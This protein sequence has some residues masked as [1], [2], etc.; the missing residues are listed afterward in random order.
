MSK[1]NVKFNIKTINLFFSSEENSIF[2]YKYIVTVA[3]CL[4]HSIED[5]CFGRQKL[6]F[7]KGREQKE[8]LKNKKNNNKPNYHKMI[9]ANRDQHVIDDIL[10]FFKKIMS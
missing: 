2:Y 6:R 1:K 3:M 5:N 7:E 10:F 9:K 4:Y 8:W